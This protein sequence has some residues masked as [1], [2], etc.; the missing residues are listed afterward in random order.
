VVDDNKCQYT[1]SDAD[2]V[3]NIDE[4]CASGLTFTKT[5]KDGVTEKSYNDIV[6]ETLSFL[7]YIESNLLND[8]IETIS[9]EF[10]AD[11]AKKF[12]EK[13]LTTED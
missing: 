6:I 1:L 5:A 3:S 9:D 13:D 4:K 8:K 12:A 2:L 7:N 11:S 10:I